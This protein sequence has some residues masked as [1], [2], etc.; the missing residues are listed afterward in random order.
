M[1][2]WNVYLYTLLASYPRLAPDPLAYQA[3]I[4]K[5]SQKFNSTSWL[6]Y[7]TAFH[8]MAASNVL[9][10]VPRSTNSSTVTSYRRKPSLLHLLSH[11]P[12][13]HPSL[14]TSPSIL[15]RSTYDLPR[16]SVEALTTSDL[17]PNSFSQP[18]SAVS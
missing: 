13:P 1:E 14:Q 17:D 8:H 9:V 5:F 12:P 11:L 16:N 6:M 18:P 10:P 2:A 3:Q 4:C 15:L 7:D